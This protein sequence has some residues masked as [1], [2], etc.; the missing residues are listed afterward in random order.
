MVLLTFQTGKAKETTPKGGAT[1]KKQ[2]Q[3][4][5]EAEDDDDDEEDESDEGINYKTYYK[6][7][8]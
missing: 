6:V 8:V 3:K 1:P 2:T 5:E 4:V 7:L